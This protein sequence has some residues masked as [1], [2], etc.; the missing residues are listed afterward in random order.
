MPAVM[1]MSHS[2]AVLAVAVALGALAAG[3]AH[4]QSMPGAGS[5]AR[6]LPPPV[7]RPNEQAP[8]AHVQPPAL[9]GTL[10]Q[11]PAAER[12][13]LDLP[14]TE[15][16]FDAINR[17]DLAAARDAINRGA[18][19]GGHNILGMTPL[20][21]SVDLSRNDI[22]FLLLSMRGGSSAPVRSTGVTP[23]P[24]A[25]PS[26]TKTASVPP[27]PGAA[28]PAPKLAAVPPRPAP[29]PAAPAPQQFAGPGSAG[30]PD[31]Q[32]GF[33]GFGGTVQ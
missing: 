16:L 3:P 9:P 19:L 7:K 6:G 8:E 24:H 21:V 4:A 5:G 25:K 1:R 33:L 13:Q 18:D 17:G 14:P 12:T 15:S 23:D 22:T 29:A 30:T 31:P 2:L 26:A 32:A 10:N 28:K 11:A 20:D 27:K